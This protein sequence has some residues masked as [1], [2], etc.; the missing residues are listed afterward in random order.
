MPEPNSS[1]KPKSLDWNLWLGPARA[2]E[3]TPNIHPLIGEVGG[4]RN[5][6]SW[7]CRMSSNRYSF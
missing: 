7:R 2:K 1:L 4:I 3:Y 6:S 5:R